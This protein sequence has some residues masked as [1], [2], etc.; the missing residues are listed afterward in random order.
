LQ[1]ISGGRFRTNT[2]KCKA[3]V[4]HS[5]ANVKLVA[6]NLVQKP[7]MID[8]KAKTILKTS[9]QIGSEIKELKEVLPAGITTFLN[10]TFDFL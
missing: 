2:R 4:V 3:N 9:I 10:Q 8:H 6:G 7:K 5:E 1:S